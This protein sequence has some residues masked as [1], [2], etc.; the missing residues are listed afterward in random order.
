MGRF[1]FSGVLLHPDHVLGFQVRLSRVVCAFG[2]G[3]SWGPLCPSVVPPRAS[4]APLWEGRLDHHD[5]PDLPHGLPLAWLRPSNQLLPRALNWIRPEAPTHRKGWGSGSPLWGSRVC[6]G[7]KEGK[8]SWGGLRRAMF[9]GPLL[10]RAHRLHYTAAGNSVAREGVSCLQTLWSPTS[11]GGEA[12]GARP[13]S[14][15]P[16]SGPEPG[17]AQLGGGGGLGRLTAGS[18]ILMPAELGEPQG[19][20]LRGPTRWGAGS[21][22]HPR[23]P[24]KPPTSE[25]G[26]QCRGP[27]SLLSPAKRHWAVAAADLLP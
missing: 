14:P 24:Q 5:L 17:P 26:T 3:R 20:G 6:G 7:A 1:S 18:L 2:G 19:R 27:A 22:R 4:Q 12:R 8:V 25:H 21:A 16:S 13:F 11:S 9:G 23:V 15:P 10:P